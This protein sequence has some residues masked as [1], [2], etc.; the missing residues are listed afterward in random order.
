MFSNVSCHLKL[1]FVEM[2]QLTLQ[3]RLC[4]PCVL[5]VICDS[6]FDS[7]VNSTHRLVSLSRSGSVAVSLG[8]T[9][10]WFVRVDFE[11]MEVF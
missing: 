8:A 4:G 1:V 11:K 6:P 10:T 5:R 7:S 2:S 9:V 3:A